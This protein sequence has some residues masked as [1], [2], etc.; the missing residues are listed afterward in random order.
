MSS[1]DFGLETS[2]Y[3]FQHSEVVGSEP[4]PFAGIETRKTTFKD[5]ILAKIYNHY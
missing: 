5:L 2:P 3:N 1:R 4:A